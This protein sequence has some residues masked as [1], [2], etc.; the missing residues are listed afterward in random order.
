VT[1]KQT[2]DG[3]KGRK[4]KKDDDDAETDRGYRLAPSEADRKPWYIK[5]KEE[6][7]PQLDPGKR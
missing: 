3:S 2:I 7:H 6:S 1:G 4:E 5:P